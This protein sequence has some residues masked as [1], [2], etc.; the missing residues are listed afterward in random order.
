LFDAG[1]DPTSPQYAQAFETVRQLNAEILAQNRLVDSLVPSGRDESAEFQTRAADNWARLHQ[2]DAGHI[3]PERRGIPSR[4][5]ETVWNPTDDS[6]TKLVRMLNQYCYRCHS[7]VLYHVFDKKAVLSWVDTMCQ[8]INETEY[9]SNWSMPQDRFL[10]EPQERR[11]VELL[12]K[13]K[14]SPVTA[15]TGAS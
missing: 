5:G 14:S 7:S 10:T 13:C 3:P 1:K 12:A 2:G 11:L 9:T 8:V 4:D 6:E 15:R